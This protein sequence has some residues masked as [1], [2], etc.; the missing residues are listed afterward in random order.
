MPKHELNVEDSFILAEK[1]LQKIT[2][3]TVKKIENYLQG[4]YKSIFQG[5][6]LD[7]KEIREYYDKDDIRNID[8]NVTARMGRPHVRVY[9]EE[10]DNIVWLILDVSSSMDFGSS[11][12][13]KKD[14]MV[15]FASLMGYLAYKRGDKIGAILFDKNIKEIIPPEKGLKQIY[16]I[17]KKLLDYESHEK[18]DSEIDFSKLVNV[19][20]KKK[21]IFFLSDFIFTDTSWKKHFGQLGVKNEL[22]VIHILDPVEENIPSVGYINLYDPET[23]KTLAFDTSNPKIKEKYQELLNEENKEIQ[24]IFSVLRLDPVKI[25]TNSDIANVLIN[26]TS[27]NRR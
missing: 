11:F 16:K 6:G 2:L 26:Y 23:G 13:T 8:W 1:I 18:D 3:P 25:Y 24:E 10:R 12:T 9:E 27:K 21:S 4:N 14:I 15:K 5:H 20:G 22:R 19:I 7:F 17:I